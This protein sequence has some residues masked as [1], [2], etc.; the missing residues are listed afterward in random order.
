VDHTPETDAKHRSAP[1]ADDCPAA[2][3]ASVDKMEPSLRLILAECRVPWLVQ[4]LLVEAEMVTTADLAQAYTKELL[5]TKYDTDFGLHKIY[6]YSSISESRSIGRLQFALTRSTEAQEERSKRR[7]SE[8]SSADETSNSERHY[9]EG[10]WFLKTGLPAPPLH[11]QG[12]SNFVMKVYKSIQ[13]NDIGDFSNNQIIS[14]NPDSSD[15]TYKK[16]KREHYVDG[17]SKDADEESRSDPHDY[18]SW[19]RQMT[20]WRNTLLMSICANPQE[21]RL[22]ISKADLDEFYDYLLVDDIYKRKPQPSL[23]TMMISERKAWRKIPRAPLQ[24]SHTGHRLDEDA[25]RLHVL[26]TR[27]V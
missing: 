21:I 10:V 13:Q 17:H 27:S 2:Y 22:Q 4:H 15:K 26:A 16:R 11:D 25:Q 23:K 6:N 3:T 7:Q 12:S 5:N 9:L 14:E 20:I 19:E 24:G 18:E 1:P 8:I